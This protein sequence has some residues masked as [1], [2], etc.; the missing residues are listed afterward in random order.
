MPEN[1]CEFR[2]V[3]QHTSKGIRV[4]TGTSGDERDDE[5]TGATSETVDAEATDETQTAKAAA[6]EADADEA[7]AGSEGVAAD[8][9]AVG[10]AAAATAVRDKRKK[11]GKTAKRSEAEAAPKQGKPSRLAKFFGEVM[12]EL[13]KVVT[14]TRKELWRY[15]LVV[16]GFLLIMMALVAL[17]DF[18]FNF[19]ASWTF[20][21]G[22]DLFP[23]PV[24]EPVETA[25]AG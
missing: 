19:L 8:D 7:G 21:E 25:P 3:G 13:K 12:A 5:L 10:T 9:A 17:F 16:I 2:R 11:Q 14:P 18:V 4:A 15:V 22:S 6:E 24:Q 23:Q 1:F 20:G